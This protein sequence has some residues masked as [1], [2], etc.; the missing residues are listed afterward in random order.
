[1][2]PV[3]DLP[4]PKLPPSRPTEP[5]SARSVGRC[6]APTPMSRTTGLAEG[7]G[8]K[9]AGQ[10]DHNTDRHNP[11]FSRTPHSGST[12]AP[13]ALARSIVVT[14]PRRSRREGLLTWCGAWP[15]R[16]AGGGP[17]RRERARG[18]AARPRTSRCRRPTRCSARAG[19]RRCG[20]GGGA[21]RPDK[22]GRPTTHHTHAR[23]HARTHAHSQPARPAAGAEAYPRGSEAEREEGA[24]GGRGGGCLREQKSQPPTPPSS[25]P[26]PT[27]SHPRARTRSL[28]AP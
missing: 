27:Q 22:G 13:L 24:A 3:H 12:L 25:S 6:R 10:E 7:R 15:L 14:C 21:P 23:T 4:N 5:L 16:S 8:R 26:P 11:L 28:A 2:D 1:M 18:P 19:A 20:R 9:G 17:R